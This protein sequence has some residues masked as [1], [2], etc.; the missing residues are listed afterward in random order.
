MN[1]LQ[2]L[3]PDGTLLTIAQH[4]V[5]A[6][7]SVL[8][9]P[10]DGS[11]KQMLPEWKHLQAI[12][13]TPAELHAWFHGHE[14]RGI[15]LIGGA[16]SGNLE[17]LDFDDKDIYQAFLDAATA[18]GLGPVMDRIRAG[19]EE[20][21]PRGVHL[22]YYCETIEG[23]KKLAS[24]PLTP[25]EIQ[26]GKK[27][28]K[29]LIETRGEKGY[30]IV[31]PSG[32]AVHE[33]GLPY[34]L[35]QGSW[36]TVAT[37]T[38]G[39]RADLWDLSQTFDRMPPRPV[40]TPSPSSQN[41]SGERPG[42]LFAQATS[43]RDILE[44]HGW[45]WAYRRG[46]VDLWRR[47]GKSLGI[48]ASTNY[49]GSDLFY[50]FSSSTAF[51]PE[52]GY[53]KFSVYAFLYHSGDFSAAAKSLAAKGFKTDRAPPLRV[54]PQELLDAEAEAFDALVQGNGHVSIWDEEENAVIVAQEREE[55]EAPAT[56]SPVHNTWPTPPLD[57][58]GDS[59]LIG[60]PPMPLGLLPPLLE[61]HAV[62]VAERLGV[63]A[64]LVALPML[65]VGAAAIDDRIRI[66]PLQHDTSWS[67]SARLWV[68]IIANSGQKKTPALNAAVAALRKVERPWLAQDAGAME[69]YHARMAVLKAAEKIQ[70]KKAA[71]MEAK[72]EECVMPPLSKPP[73]KPPVRRKEV[74]DITIEALSEVFID[75]EWGLLAVYD[76]LT[77]WFGNFDSYRA[78][79]VKKDRALYLEA[80]NGGPQIIDRIMR[81]HVYVPNWSLS[82]VGGIQPEA[83]RKLSG[84]LT[85]DGLV[86]R[87]ITV[88]APEDS[89]PVD[90]TEDPDAKAD[91][92]R[93]IS[94]LCSWDIG[95]PDARIFCKF[96][97]EVHPLRELLNSRLRLVGSMPW[98][99]NAFKTHLSKWEGLFPRLCLTWHCIQESAVYP[100]PETIPVETAQHVFTF[101]LEYL[102]PHA[103][104]F[105]T[106]VLQGKEEEE[107]VKWI[108]GHILAHDLLKI[109]SRTIG[110][111]YRP[112]R[113][114]TK[115]IEKTMDWLTA[116]SW[117]TPASEG[118][119]P[120]QWTVNPAVHTLF[121]TRKEQE[122]NHRAQ[123]IQRIQE[124]VRNFP[125]LATN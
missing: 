30:V 97:P 122:K 58:F 108:A 12:R 16:I 47:P 9:I 114:D 79:A 6:G 70:Q 59:R 46:E 31:A 53:G 50:C 27:G 93:L 37:I 105:Y 72:G 21:S 48:S 23:S 57:V 63:D 14:E 34:T 55:E 94:R 71:A 44:P 83:M 4:Y 78:A 33:L 17:I 20:A 41:G 95:G 54:V 89:I 88:F 22:P 110:R 118:R 38:T 90:R 64:A 87:F 13:P 119:S 77:A 43:W 74:K 107:H 51:D 103:A 68:A 124:A 7:F 11:K 52:R 15:A 67:E 8:P 66:R 25:E 123:V 101:M 60:S 86:Q 125:A 62:D 5:A 116:L 61:R 113:G 92:D 115:N 24:R 91:Y 112:L 80:Y 45:T 69:T 85:D 49:A 76:E 40:Y 117:V 111:V 102:L 28:I 96:A 10:P 42:D 75:N 19:C 98:V 120:T 1:T 121:V 3:A 104:R 2:T 106:E 99:T 26:A 18:S 100:F 84:Q 29:G 35:V 39:E 81:G 36:F 82:L 73:Q 32:G 56:T 109:S 65:A